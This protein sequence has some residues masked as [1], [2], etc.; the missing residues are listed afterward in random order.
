M[1]ASEIM[2]RRPAY[3]RSSA[4]VRDALEAL[5]SLDVRH[6]PVVNEDDELVGMLSDRDF[7]GDPR[8]DPTLID[9]LGPSTQALDAR[10]TELMR[11]D[12]VSVSEDTDVQDIA[13]SLVEQKIGAV[14]VVSPAGQLVGIVSYVDLLRELASKLS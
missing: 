10:V 12:V 8:P 1:I 4:R 13:E 7:S 14:P 5:R 9:V 6:L 3:I 11:T 2:T